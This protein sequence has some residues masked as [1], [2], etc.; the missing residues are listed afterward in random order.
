MDFSY[1]DEQQLLQ[2]SVARFV[3][4]Q[5]S[6]DARRR[7]LA[8]ATGFSAANWRLFAELGWLA[9]AIPEADGG[10]GGSVIDCTLLFEQ[11]GKGLVVEPYL[12][13]VMLGGGIVT[14]LGSSAQ[15]AAVLP[16]L[17]AGELQLALGFA[18][19]DSRYQLDA[20]QTRAKRDGAGWMLDGNKCV[21]L[22][23]ANADLVLVSARDESDRLGI[24]QVAPGTQG[25]TLKSYPTIDGAH[26]AEIELRGVRLKADA[27]LAASD[28][29]LELSLIHI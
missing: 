28:D 24:F 8:E 6:F 5:Y 2:D 21:V 18:E 20:V 7:V 4:E 12:A 10:L 29:A 16:A 26:A 17:A 27:R 19:P 13:S 25:L 11:F 15:R 3:R 23:A 14:E 9:V 22:N 1:S